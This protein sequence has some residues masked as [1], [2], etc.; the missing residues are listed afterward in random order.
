M[1]AAFFDRVGDPSVIRWAALADPAAGAG[2]VVVRPEAVAVDA[3]DTL[4]RSGRWQTP[5]TPP[6]AVGRDLIGVVDEVGAGVT[7]IAVGDRVWTSS[8]GY[9][10]RPGATAER[11]VVDVDRIYPAPPGAD[12]VEFVAAVHPAT[13]A[14][15][16][17]HLRARIQPGET[18]LI[19]GANGSVGA[20]LVQEGLA[21][22][23]DVV[24]ATRD[25]RAAEILRSWGAEGVVAD[26]GGVAEALVARRPGGADVFIDASGHADTAGVVTQLTRRGR[27]IVLA[28]RTSAD[29]DLWSLQTRELRIEGFILSALDVGELR[30][31]AG[32]LVARWRDGR[33]PRARVG[34]VMSFAD[35]ETAHRR[36]EGGALGR[37]D[38]GFVERLVLVP[39]TPGEVSG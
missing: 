4:V 36:I 14:I 7:D 28:G 22:G 11:V 25:A 6:T 1:H 20:A 3:V 15:A 5:L 21:A 16:A 39:P 34:E 24:A 27:V 30:W 31:V 13:T 2:Q 29:I 33:A 8:A 10:G 12:A 9:D 26:G 35:A 23:A 18:L 38:D 32:E 17:L 19:A 37:T